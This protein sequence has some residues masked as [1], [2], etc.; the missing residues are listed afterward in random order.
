MAATEMVW[1]FFFFFKMCLTIVLCHY[2]TLSFPV[3]DEMM[4]ALF[5]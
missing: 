5:E 2:M 1:G 4:L 3:V